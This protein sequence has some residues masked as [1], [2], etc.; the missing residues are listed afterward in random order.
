MPDD[1][2]DVA[3]WIMAF[4][5]R[6]VARQFPFRVRPPRETCGRREMRKVV[7]AVIAAWFKVDCVCSVCDNK[8]AS[9]CLGLS[10]PHGY[11]L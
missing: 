8:Q 7:V 1:G 10:W 6:L 2:D 4:H 3:Y 9:S 11:S 5:V